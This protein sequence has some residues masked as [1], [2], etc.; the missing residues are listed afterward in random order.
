[1]LPQMMLVLAQSPVPSAFNT[2]AWSRQTFARRL[3]ADSSCLRADGPLAAAPSVCNPSLRGPQQTL[4][5]I[6]ENSGSSAAGAAPSA[7]AMLCWHGAYM[8]PRLIQRYR[9][10]AIVEIG[11]CTG[12]TTANVVEQLKPNGLERYYLVDPWGGL[13]CRPGC[14]CARHL[15]A[16]ARAWPDVLVPLRG[17]ASARIDPVHAPASVPTR[18]ARRRPNT[19]R[20]HMSTRPPCD[21]TQAPMLV[22]CVRPR[23]DSVSMAS[24]IPNGSLDLVFVDAAHDYRNVRADIIA[25]WPKLKPTGVMAGHD[26][27]HWRN[28]AE[29]RQDRLDR[30][31]PWGRVPTAKGKPLPPA[32]GVGQATQELFSAC[33]VRVSFNVWWVER[34]T[35]MAGPQLTLTSEQS[36]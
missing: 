17:C 19:P 27:A 28:W 3:L 22:A 25:Y 23:I 26:F 11:V 4:V 13:K 5:G 33:E 34:T 35:C 8:L 15:R 2:T 21:H 32:Y 24:N 14:G 10:R 29:I 31:G 30:R 16:M 18:H 6:A 9:A 1:M 12:M 36:P 7:C 20:E